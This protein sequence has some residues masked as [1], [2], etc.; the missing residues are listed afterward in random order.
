MKCVLG[1]W[2]WWNGEFEV[3]PLYEMWFESMVV[4]KRLV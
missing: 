3:L 2:L 4:V 1:E